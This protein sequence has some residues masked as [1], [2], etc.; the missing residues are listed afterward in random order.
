M[1]L[2]KL[3]KQITWQLRECVEL[4]V[5]HQL[6]YPL[7]W[8]IWSKVGLPTRKALNQILPSIIA[9]AKEDISGSR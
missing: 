8:V 6:P 7:Y 5:E 4:P 2:G 1:D 9:Q 3:N